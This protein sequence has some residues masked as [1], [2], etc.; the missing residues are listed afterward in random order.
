MSKKRDENRTNTL[1]DYIIQKLSSQATK[2]PYY[3][4]RPKRS[5]PTITFKDKYHI[6]H[7]SIRECERRLRK[8][9]PEQ[10]KH[11]EEEIK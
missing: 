11:Y 6:P 3:A 4:E 5:L 2:R 1:L 9:K 7:Q 8:Y 10:L